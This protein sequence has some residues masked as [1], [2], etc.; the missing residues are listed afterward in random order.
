MTRTA[1][2]R[3]ARTSTS[4]RRLLVYTHR[5]LGIVG[6]LLFVAWFV[7]GVVL[8][9]VGMPV[10]DPDDRLRRL[11]PLDL[12]RAAVDVGE[13]A[14]TA[15]FAPTRILV[16]MLGD[17]PVFRFSGG[18]SWTTV[19]ADTGEALTG[20]DRA[21]ALA[22]AR[23]FAPGHAATVSHD[24][25]L[26]APDQWTLQSRAFLPLHRV[27]LGDAA[28]TVLY[29]SERTGEPVM[30][31]TRSARRWAYAGAVP[32]WLY[33]TP[34]RA[35][36]G[37]WTEVVIWAAIAGCLL[38]LSGLVWGLWRVGAARRYRLRQ[39]LSRSPYAGWMRWHHYAGLAFGVVTFTWVFSGGLSMEPWSWHPGTAPTAAQRTLLS[40][41]PLRLGLL[42]ASQIQA[43]LSVL[44]GPRVPR[45]LEVFQFLGVP[46]LRAVD[47]PVD[48]GDHTLPT[49]LAPLGS[50]GPRQRLVSADAPERGVFERFDAS[51][52]EVLSV[53]AM[54]GV[55]VVDAEWLRGYDDYY[56]DRSGRRRLPIY[57][58]RY[59]DRDATWLYFDPFRGAIARREV[60]LT[61][62]NRWLYHGLHSLDFS[63]LYTR[64][65]LWDLVVILLSLGGLAV[66]VTPLAQAWRRLR[67]HG[68]RI[69]AG[70][71]PETAEVP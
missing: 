12:S 71:R 14:V 20:L 43:G 23:R 29:I 21:E 26:T 70:N 47:P 3:S 34:L 63:W 19:Y 56:Y 49:T 31:T 57:R 58:V 68:G 59:D 2:A 62:L 5:W 15:G 61:R 65:P 41:G 8:M 13:A 45:E 24:G 33:F 16:G 27:R 67:R 66:S 50:R 44:A 18:A 69:G 7:S 6:S 48:A 9:Y 35:R 38:C 17:R 28:D 30:R 40:G 10:L 37:L 39:G 4:W 53:E 32:H 54:P 46:Y 51:V 52:F 42:T 1:V 64:R 22:L 25:R 11:P 55:R 60:R 36:A